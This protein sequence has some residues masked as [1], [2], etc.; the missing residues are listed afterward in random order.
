M[1]KFFSLMLSMLLAA[2]LPM[3]AFA[4]PDWPADTGVQSE[5][6]IVMDMDSETVLF[7]QNLHAQ[8]A[9]ASITKVLTALV[10]VENSS[11]DDVITYSHDAVYNVESGS[12]N[13]NAIE[14]G[15][16]MTVRDALHHML[17]TSSNQSA[18][19][20]AEHVGGT[21]DGFVEMMNEKAAEIGCT[22]SHF[23]N[24]SGLNDDS[25]LTTVYDMALIGKAAYENETLLEI[26]SAKSYRLPATANNPEGVTVYMEHQMMKEDSEFYYPYTV[27]GKT[28]YTSIAGQT[29]L[30]YAEKDDRRQISV[31]MKSTQFT[32]YSDTISLM[33]FGFRRFQNVNISENET[34]YTTG[35][36]PV[37]LGERSYEPSDLSLDTSAVI[38]IPKDA[39]FTDAEKKVVTDLPEDHPDGAAALLTYTYN[40]RK[41]GEVYVISASK[42]AEDAKAAEAAAVGAAAGEAPD[43]ANPAKPENADE[44]DGSESAGRQ[45]LPEQK[46]DQENGASSAS[47]EGISGK[48]ALAGVLVFL[49]VAAVGTA[50]WYMKKQQAE[51]RK[52]MEERR[53]RRRQR[54]EEMG[55]TQE[56]FDRLRAQRALREKTAEKTAGAPEDTSE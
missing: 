20:L 46:P 11:L 8:K 4:R 33:D 6:G 50:V 26:A 37:E 52:R 15:D 19:A 7:G 49:V 17:L 31:T 18:N 40:D 23:A 27:T 41:V 12:G 34:A 55:C 43:A 51:E 28:G 56:E 9:P 47:S 38:T 42:A 24:P 21:R 29:L 39:V 22:E 5:A 13:K 1:K 54:L 32:H 25:Q 16:Q 14:E 30:T 45:N 2:A 48:A 53:M 44:S 36:Q 35:D 10:V 3:T